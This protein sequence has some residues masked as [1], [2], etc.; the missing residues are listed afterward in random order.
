MNYT[1]YL[2]RYRHVAKEIYRNSISF[3]AMETVMVHNY[4]K[5]KGGQ[6]MIIGVKNKTLSVY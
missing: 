5:L 3:V 4:N 2:S 1:P 6:G